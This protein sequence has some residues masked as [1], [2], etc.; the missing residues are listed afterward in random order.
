MD[1]LEARTVALEA[2]RDD[3]IQ[4]A[5]DT[6]KQLHALT[7]DVKEQ[8]NEMKRQERKLEKLAELSR[9][10]TGDNGDLTEVHSVL[11]KIR[12]DIDR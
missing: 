8:S 11:L 12:I 3:A 7:A 10:L 2:E 4:R 5:E 6:A 9:K 1:W